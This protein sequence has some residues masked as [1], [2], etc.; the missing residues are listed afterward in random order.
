MLNVTDPSSRRVLTESDPEQ[1]LGRRPGAS[2][3]IMTGVVTDGFRFGV[4]AYRRGRGVTG[5]LPALDDR[6]EWPLARFRTWTWPTWEEPT[7]HEYLKPSY[8]ALQQL[9]GAP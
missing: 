5:A 3:S 6:G 4:V 2:P 9:W 1:A 8:R 7:W